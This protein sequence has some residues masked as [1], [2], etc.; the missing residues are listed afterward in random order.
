MAVVVRGWDMPKNC[1][2][3]PFHKPMPYKLQCVVTGSCYSYAEGANRA[4]N[5]PLSRIGRPGDDETD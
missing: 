4:K 5:C 2:D 1:Y 3:C